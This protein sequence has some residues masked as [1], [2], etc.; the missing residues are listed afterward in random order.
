MPELPEVETIKRDLG[1][2]AMGK[3]IIGVEVRKGK[4]VQGSA[5]GFRKKLT[6]KSFKEIS[7]AGKLLVFHLSSGD[8]LL[9]H[10]KMTGQLIYQK[11]KRTT[12]GGHKI[13]DKDL[14]RL[15]NKYT[16]IIFTF[17]DGS[18]LFFN[19]MRQFGYMRL[20]GKKERLKVESGYGIDPLAAGFTRKKFLGMMKG[21]K[22]KIKAVLMD[23]KFIAGIGNIYV[24]EI[25]FEAGVRPD[26]RVESLSETEK[27]KIFEKCVSILKKAVK[28][29]GTTFRDF[30]G[31][32]GKPGGFAR[33]LKVYQKE[34]GL[35]PRC[36]K[37]KIK[38]MKVA[39]RGTRYCPVCQR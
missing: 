35:C 1:K 11:G 25:C 22:G 19:D 3:K 26:R 30:R 24:D 20:V 13:S 36:R 12:A 8:F 23:Q 32:E 38:K 2:V 31:G 4:M 14:E 27:G 6:G 29:K 28:Y 7:R 10:L 33:F 9:V 21:K 17:A 39:G 18:K 37:G 16:H 34:S 15:P 5:A